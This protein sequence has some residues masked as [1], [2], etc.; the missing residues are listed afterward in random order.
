MLNFAVQYGLD[1]KAKNYFNK[2]LESIKFQNSLHKL[3]CIEYCYL[4]NTFT[5]GQ[6]TY[7]SSSFYTFI[8]F[9]TS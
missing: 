9:K 3:R 1:L 2:I 4:R 7:A 5:F 8:K 6:N